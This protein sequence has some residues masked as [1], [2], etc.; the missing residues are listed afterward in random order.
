MNDARM[1]SKKMV[2]AKLLCWCLVWGWGVQQFRTSLSVYLSFC[3]SIMSCHV[4][5]RYP[6]FVFFHQFC[7]CFSS[8]HCCL[9][10]TI[11][12]MYILTLLLQ[13]MI[14]WSLSSFYVHVA[15]L[16]MNDSLPCA[17]LYSMSKMQE[18]M[19]SNKN[20]KVN[21]TRGTKVSHSRILLLISNDPTQICLPLV[22]PIPQSLQLLIVQQSLNHTMTVINNHLQRQPSTGMPRNM[23]MN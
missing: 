21:P 12:M 8:Y 10:I 6:V 17:P 16:L 2:V 7:F 15:S 19:P 4:M 13:A 22:T 14:Q 1:S 3:L 9:T 20:Q 18:C 23:T 5:S 11:L